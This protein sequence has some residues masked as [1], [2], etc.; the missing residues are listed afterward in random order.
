[1]SFTAPHVGF[2]LVS[3]GFSTLVLCGLTAIVL[4][5]A[6]SAANRLKDLEARA[7]RRRKPAKPVNPA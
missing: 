5:Q 3:Y 4:W 6:R 7:V 1:M 2:V